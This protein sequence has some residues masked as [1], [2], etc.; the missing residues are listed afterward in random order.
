M[1]HDHDLNV[2]VWC[3]NCEHTHVPNIP[4]FTWGCFSCGFGSWQMEV[5]KG[6][7]TRF[8]DHGIYR[9]EHRTVPME[10]KP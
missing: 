8:A 10:G 7:Q 6:H 4:E 9:E 2:S 3:L 5:A 1:S